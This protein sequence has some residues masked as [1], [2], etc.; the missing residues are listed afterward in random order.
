[1]RPKVKK[2]RAYTQEQIA[3]L[4]R[5]YLKMNIRDLTLAFN[6]YYG[7]S[8][9]E[10]QIKSTLQNHHIR[11]G[12]RP[13]ERLVNPKRLLNREQERFLRKTYRKMSLADTVLAL[14]HRFGLELTEEQVKTYVTNHH[15][16]SGRTGC[17]EKGH[18]P[19]NTGTKGICKPTKGSFRKGNVPANRK[20]LYSE[21]ICTK[22]GYILMKVP[23]RN[24]HSGAPTRY[25]AKH[26]WIW[27]QAH[28]PAPEGMAVMFRDGDKTNCELD[29]LMLV[30]RGE[31]LN[32]NRNHKYKDAPPEVKPAILALSKLQLTI[33]AREKNKRR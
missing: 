26:V 17:F 29:N 30:S 31:L 20:P 15:I 18:K 21:R 19:W 10:S 2:P 6:E 3:F 14:T 1:M 28:G 9:T 12:R 23:E 27:E 8:K 22:D 33:W 4:Q 7:M 25:K 11:C 13:G 16:L 32:L 5:G 24:P